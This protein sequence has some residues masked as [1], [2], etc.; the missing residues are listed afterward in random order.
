MTFDLSLSESAGSR[1]LDRLVR[2]RSRWLG[3]E[4]HGL[5][6]SEVACASRV[7]LCQERLPHCGHL[8]KEKA[9]DRP[10]AFQRR[11]PNSQMDRAKPHEHRIIHDRESASMLSAHRRGRMGPVIS[12]VSG[13]QGTVFA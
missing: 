12:F 6:G 5:G 10:A 1:S 2:R 8:M 3:P 4:S 11:P 9:R 13:D 7:S